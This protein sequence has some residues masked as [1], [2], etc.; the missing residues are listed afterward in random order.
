MITTVTYPPITANI[1]DSFT[2]T[3]S[4]FT[5]GTNYTGLMITYYNPTPQQKQNVRTLVD[6]LASYD[7]TKTAQVV[8][9]II[10][11][12]SVLG[13]TGSR[14]QESP[15]VLFFYPT[16]PDQL[17]F[18]WNFNTTV[19]LAFSFMHSGTDGVR[20]TT[21]NEFLMTKAKFLCLNG[22]NAHSST[23]PSPIEATRLIS[24]CA[25]CLN[26]LTTPF[27]TE[28]LQVAYPTY[29]LIVCHQMAGFDNVPGD[30]AIPTG[31][32]NLW[33]INEC[34]QDYTTTTKSFATLLAIAFAQTPIND[35]P[36]VVKGKF[37][38]NFITFNGVQYSMTDYSGS[39]SFVYKYRTPLPNTDVQ[40]HIVN[41]PIGAGL[42]QQGTD[43]GRG[44]HIEHADQ[45]K[46][47]H[48]T[49]NTDQQT[50]IN[51]MITATDWYTRWNPNV[52]NIANIPANIGHFPQW[53]ECALMNM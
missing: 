18:C 50:L 45:Y 10:A 28:T 53:F 19:K 17:V 5:L 8:S 14:I 30:Q 27:L 42:S 21:F 29:P 51:A 23:L 1:F 3:S 49:P 52:H 36:V 22:M 15:D 12:L 20:N 38:G 4:I 31:A 34:N 24:D 46:V 35:G 43:S 41:N 2:S 32:M 7:T 13:M 39:P 44:V 25:H 26:N 37:V 47:D 16:V 11:A 48:V 40:N 6:A 33:F 9:S